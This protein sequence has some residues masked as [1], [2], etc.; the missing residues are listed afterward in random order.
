MF[1][2]MSRIPLTQALLDAQLAE[3]G[4]PPY[5]GPDTP[6]GLRRACV[7]AVR[8]AYDSA[9][10]PHRAVL[11][12]AVRFLLDELAAKAPGKSVEVRVPPY[13]AVQCVEGTRHTRGT[14]PNVVEM[15]A[16]TWI[17]LATAALTWADAVHD[18]RI[19]ASGP[20][21][22]LTPYLPVVS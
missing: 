19:R 9:A 2:P 11:K 12:G 20:R 15:D 6:A 10:E 14:P 4:Q 17:D 8:A 22:D 5:A 13:A 21:A 16:R 3:L 18:G 7:A 1:G